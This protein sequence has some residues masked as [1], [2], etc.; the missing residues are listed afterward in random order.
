MD[1]VGICFFIARLFIY[2]LKQRKEEVLMISTGS[3][4]DI[5]CD[6]GLGKMQFSKAFWFAI[7]FFK[8]EED[9]LNEIS[10]F[11]II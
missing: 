9:F 2:I 6:K 4:A 3:L 10:F 1:A 7:F 5:I 11:G 8:E